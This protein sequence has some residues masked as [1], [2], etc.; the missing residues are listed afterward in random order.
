VNAATLRRRLAF[1]IVSTA[2]MS[3]AF[4]MQ[5]PA[6]AAPARTAKLK[7]VAFKTSP[8]PYE[9]Q[10]PG[11]DKPFLDTEKD[12]RRGHTAR[13]GT[14]YWE[15]TTYS[16]RRA[17]LFIPKGFDPA[18]RG[19][20]VVYFHGNQAALERDVWR[21]Q[22]VP[23]QLAQS[24]LN[25]VLVAPQFAVDALDSSAGQ[26]WE[27]RAFRRYLEEAAEH[28]A[29]LYGDPWGS[30]KFDALGVVIV[31]YSGG[32][33]PAAW[34]MH[35]GG[36]GDRL[37]GVVMLDALYGEFDTYL[38]WIARRESAFFFSAYSRSVREENATFQKLLAE[39]N[40][41]FATAMPGKLAPGSVTFVDTGEEVLHNDF[42]TKAWADDPLRDVLARIPGYSRTPPPKPIR[43]R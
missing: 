16:D 18:R 43:R 26:F 11:R 13:G 21:R 3:V 32:Y 19:L 39:R 17:L 14:V 41:D 22:Q 15:D 1:A 25:A 10:P 38:R 27:P 7:L 9:G 8:F 23:R 33:F 31:A 42:V 28:L 30:A 24:D 36:V 34:A 40:I 4:S 29:R 6:S 35:H 5:G 20:I 37:R 12:G 2:I